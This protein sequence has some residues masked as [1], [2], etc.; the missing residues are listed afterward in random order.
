MF[1]VCLNCGQYNAEKTIDTRGAPQG[2]AKAICPECGHVHPFRY[3]PLLLITGASATGKTTICDTLS[4]QLQGILILDNDILWQPEFA[5]NHD[6]HRRFFET[7]LRMAKNL[8]QSGQQVVLFGAGTG[9]PENIETCTERRYFPEVH[10]LAYVCDGDVLEARLRARPAWRGCNDA[11][12]HA[13]RAFNA[14]F[15]T[16][17][18]TLTPPVDLIDTSVHTLDQ[19]ADLSKAWIREHLVPASNSRD[20]IQQ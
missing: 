6:N 19:T 7:W 11:F 12:I 20:W 4:R 1:N 5:D 2:W 3:L 18:P 14:W 13:Q 15:K 8:H 17:G 9:V 16:T 10:R